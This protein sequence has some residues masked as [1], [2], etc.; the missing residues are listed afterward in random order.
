MDQV[1]DF[2]FCKFECLDYPVGDTYNNASLIGYLS[3]YDTSIFL[4]GD[5]E[6]EVEE[7]LILRPVDILKV[8]HHGSKSSSTHD[9]IDA[10][11]PDNALIC[12][13]KNNYGHPSQEVLNRYIS[14]NIPLYKTLDGCV[15][16]WVLPFNIYFIKSLN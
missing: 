4:T 9:F 2:S 7:K 12:V 11:S 14:R 5:I 15:K 10:L 16:V 6:A 8:P 13:G 1:F 3:I